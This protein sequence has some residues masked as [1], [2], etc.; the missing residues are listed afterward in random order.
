MKVKVLTKLSRAINFYLAV[1]QKVFVLQ[2]K[3]AECNS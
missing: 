3:A 2:T 1:Y